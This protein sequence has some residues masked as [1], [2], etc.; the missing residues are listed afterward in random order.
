[1]LVWRGEPLRMSQPPNE[2]SG[3]LDQLGDVVDDVLGEDLEPP[4]E[5]EDPWE[6]RRRILDSWTA[7]IL[8]I[9][10]LAT[11]WAA[12][13]A[14]QWSGAQSDAQSAA[15]IYRSDAGRTATEASRAQ[16]VDSQMWL[17][18]LDATSGGDTAKAAFLRARFSAPLD[19]AQKQWLHGVTVAADGRPSFIPPGTPMDQPAY[20]VPSQ[21][22]SDSLSATAE[23]KLGEADRASAHST[24][25][26]VLAVVLA[27][28]LLFAGVATKF[29]S[30][31]LQVL[32]I[33]G[34]IA[35]LV[36]CVIRFL[37]LPEL[38]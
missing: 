2:D 11:A 28:V 10:A 38:L 31:K 26:V 29:S 13:Q 25:F 16:I 9:A 19:A 3:F 34:S 22:K 21:V 5:P 24:R 8:G 37:M 33:L 14:S 30:P 36:F 15:A 17:D 35:L 4:Q 6:R 27:L 12:F 32:L 18:W 23:A 20:V 7:I 1:M